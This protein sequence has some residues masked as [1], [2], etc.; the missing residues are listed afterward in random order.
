MAGEP[1][2]DR[3]RTNQTACTNLTTA[4]FGDLVR[5][6]QAARAGPPR[7]KRLTPESSPCRNRT[8][9]RDSGWFVRQD[10]LRG[11]RASRHDRFR[12]LG[13]ASPDE[14]SGDVAM[15]RSGPAAVAADH[16]SRPSTPRRLAGS[17]AI[18]SPGRRSPRRSVTAGAGRDPLQMRLGSETA[19]ARGAG[20]GRPDAEQRPLVDGLRTR[21]SALRSSR[22]L[23][24]RE[25]PSSAR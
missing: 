7:L 9:S 18:V 14:L 10:S 1:A 15:A 21:S 4:V 24:G 20:C 16:R 8:K 11:K 22:P 17:G 19:E 2:P 12:L 23:P 5:A 6:P 25:S 13:A 3:C